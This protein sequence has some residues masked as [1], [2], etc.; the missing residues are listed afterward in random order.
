MPQRIVNMYATEHVLWQPLAL[1]CD[2][3][4]W[5]A[6][7]ALGRDAS[8]FHGQFGPRGHSLGSWPV[9][10]ARAL[11]PS[12]GARARDT[13]GVRPKLQRSFAE[14]DFSERSTA[15]QA[16]HGRALLFHERLTDRFQPCTEYSATSSEI[17]TATHRRSRL[18]SCRRR[19]TSNPPPRT[20]MRSTAAVRAARSPLRRKAATACRALLG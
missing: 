13:L 10:D 15:A 8:F 16:R 12:T 1:W 2:G 7:R 3:Y 9:T 5:A 20:T 11:W 4:W 17:T 18:L 14:G 6:R 19:S